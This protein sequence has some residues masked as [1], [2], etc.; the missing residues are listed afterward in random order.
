M[1]CDSDEA[2]NLVQ[3]LFCKIWEQRQVLKIQSELKPYLH[4]AVYFSAINQL[5]RQHKLVYDMDKATANDTRQ[6]ENLFQVNELMDMVQDAIQQ[7]PEKRHEIFKLSRMEQL[8]YKEIAD[9]LQ[10]SIKTLSTKW[11]KRF[12]ACAAH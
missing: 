8:T 10:I 1:L 6:T 5:K 3:H 9:R 2:E 4:K 7:L 11:V 12:K